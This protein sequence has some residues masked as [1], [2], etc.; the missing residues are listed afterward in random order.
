MVGGEGSRGEG[1][2]H[3]RAARTELCRHLFDRFADGIGGVCGGGDG[4]SPQ[5]GWNVR[6]CP[7]RRKVP[8]G[9]FLN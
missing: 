9:N 6:A 2:D 8:S 4:G 7:H 1:E 5:H 3:V